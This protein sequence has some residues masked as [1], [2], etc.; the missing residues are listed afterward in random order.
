M[1][2][3]S[4]Y[5]DPET[6]VHSRQLTSY[7][8][9]SCRYWAGSIGLARFLAI[10]LGGCPSLRPFNEAMDGVGCYRSRTRSTN[11]PSRPLDTTTTPDSKNG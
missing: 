10:S 1:I 9:T 2:R 6:P 5:P 11:T 4:H 7:R 8:D 3:N